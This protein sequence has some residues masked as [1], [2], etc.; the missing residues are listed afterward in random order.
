MK[1]FSS[2]HVSLCHHQIPHTWLSCPAS[3]VLGTH[4]VFPL[5]PPTPPLCRHFSLDVSKWDSACEVVLLHAGVAPLCCHGVAAIP[6]WSRN[7]HAD[8]VPEVTLQ[9][10]PVVVWCPRW[11]WVGHRLCFHHG[12]RDRAWLLGAAA[13]WHGAVERTVQIR[14]H[15]RAEVLLSRNYSDESENVYVHVSCVTKLIF[16]ECSF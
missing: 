7:V 13:V 15:L 14:H 8:H 2:L 6:S 12:H 3:R 9:R 1:H 10:A 11:R 5:I 16:Y 4:L